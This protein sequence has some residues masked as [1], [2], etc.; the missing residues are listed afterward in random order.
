MLF[1]LVRTHDSN[2]ELRRQLSRPA[3]FRI[4][5]R[6]EEGS[7]RW[8]LA[9]HRFSVR[10]H[11]SGGRTDRRGGGNA[12]KR[13][14]PSRG[15]RRRRGEEGRKGN[16]SEI[17]NCLDSGTRL[18]VRSLRRG[19]RWRARAFGAWCGRPIRTDCSEAERCHRLGV[20]GAFGDGIHGGDAASTKIKY[21][22]EKSEQVRERRGAAKRT[23]ELVQGAAPG[24]SWDWQRCG[25][26]RCAEVGKGVGLRLR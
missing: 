10:D 13:P 24:L 6:E 19:K 18:L 17:F 8:T 1:I 26:G 5:A 3:F 21:F 12:A 4:R 7:R 22:H 16:F 9:L 11:R 23:R 25:C 14:F 20:L 2:L 15:R